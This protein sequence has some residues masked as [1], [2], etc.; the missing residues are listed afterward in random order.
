[1][2]KITIEIED[3]VFHHL[4][5]YADSLTWDDVNNAALSEQTT[6][7]PEKAA[8]HLIAKHLIPDPKPID[9]ENPF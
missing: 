8:A 3:D 6:T 7:T 1:M 2:K 5:L 9:D 4:K